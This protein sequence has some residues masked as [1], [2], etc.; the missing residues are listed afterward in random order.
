MN[1][2]LIVGITIIVILTLCICACTM[3]DAMSITLHDP[4]SG[5]LYNYGGPPPAPIQPTAPPLQPPAYE[6]IFELNRAH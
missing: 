1:A 2:L 3:L 6:E 5:N 4:V